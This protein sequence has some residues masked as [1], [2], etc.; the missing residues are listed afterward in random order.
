MED[1][2]LLAVNKLSQNLL[3]MVIFTAKIKVKYA[4]KYKLEEYAN[5]GTYI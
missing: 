3:R 4:A 1:T 5:K 2:Y